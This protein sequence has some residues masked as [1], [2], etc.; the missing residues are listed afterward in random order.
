MLKIIRVSTFA[1]FSNFLLFYIPSIEPYLIPRCRIRYNMTGVAP[2]VIYLLLLFVECFGVLCIQSLPS[3]TGINWIPNFRPIGVFIEWDMYFTKIS[4][5]RIEWFLKSL[6]SLIISFIL[7][8]F[9]II[10]PHTQEEWKRSF[11]LLSKSCKEYTY[12]F[13]FKNDLIL[14]FPIF[15]LV[16]NN[17]VSTH[18]TRKSLF[19]FL[20]TLL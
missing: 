16:C 4:L 15:I 9:E 7:R 8:D 19:S 20:W 5:S 12:T 2:F 14:T 13:G 6:V 17:D 1:W 10:S 11:L 18:L 3:L